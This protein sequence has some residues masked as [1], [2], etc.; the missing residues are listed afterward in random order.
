MVRVCDDKYIEDNFGY[1]M[2]GMIVFVLKDVQSRTAC[3]QFSFLVRLTNKSRILACID[4][5][6]SA[7]WGKLLTRLKTNN[8]YHFFPSSYVGDNN[9]RLKKR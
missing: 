3:K 5:V 9:F 2:F 6:F 1:I 4:D 7:K 8:Y